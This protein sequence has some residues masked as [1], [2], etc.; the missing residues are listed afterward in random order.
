[1]LTPDVLTY[2]DRSVLCWLATVDA[3]GHP[4]VSPKEAFT[5]YGDSQLLIANIASPTSARNVLGNPKVCVSFVDVFVQKG[6]KVKGMATLIAPSDEAFSRLEAPLRTITQGK[7]P[8]QSIFKVQASSMQPI[9]APSYWLCPA[10]TEE[11]QVQSAMQTYKVR[12]ES[13]AEAKP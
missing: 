4:S 8:I 13:S 11:M 5:A 9:V 2:I 6:Y 7:F 1:M 3:E 10:I 12:K